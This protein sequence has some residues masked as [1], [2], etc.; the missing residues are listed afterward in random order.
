MLELVREF[1][2]DV[3]LITPR[4]KHREWRPVLTRDGQGRVC[5]KCG[6]L[7]E[8]SKEMFWA[9]FGRIPKA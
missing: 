9:Y 2:E 1:L 7:E 3:G 5:R 6:A 4:C 8:L